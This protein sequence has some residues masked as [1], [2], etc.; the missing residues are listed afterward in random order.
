LETI[1]KEISSTIE[2]TLDKGIIESIKYIK[3]SDGKTFPPSKLPEDVKQLQGFIWRE[4]E[5]PKKMQDIF[6][7][8]ST[9]IERNENKKSNSIEKV[10][11]AKEIKDIELETKN[12]SA[13][14]LRK[15]SKEKLTI[16]SKKQ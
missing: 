9:E 13:K 11:D 8:N 1:T 5:Q 7:K 2:F 14:K 4:D 12:K 10:K 3:K 15:K 6:I 16:F